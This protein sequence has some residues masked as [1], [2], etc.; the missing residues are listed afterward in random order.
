MTAIIDAGKCQKSGE[1]L[2]VCPSEAIVIGDEA[3]EVDADLCADCGVCE[4][5]CPNEAITIE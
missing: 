3:A 4:E 5:V 1:C 2:D